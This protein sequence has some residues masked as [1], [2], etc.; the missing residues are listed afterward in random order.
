MIYTIKYQPLCFTQDLA[1][2][3]CSGILTHGLLRQ[4]LYSNT[5][6]KRATNKSVSLY[7]F[8]YLGHLV[9]LQAYVV[10]RNASPQ[11][12]VN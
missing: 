2:T 7:A 9:Y 11:K 8:I 5:L 12:M 6:H 1:K 4:T 10:D 3:Y